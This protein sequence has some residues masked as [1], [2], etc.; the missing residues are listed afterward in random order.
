MKRCLPLLALLACSPP[1][2][3]T[4][5]QMKVDVDP[6]ADET[7]ARFLDLFDDAQDT[8]DVALPALEDTTLAQGI[9]DAWQRGVDVRVV[10]DFDQAGDAGVALLQAADVPLTLADD[11]I[12]YFDFNLKAD[13]AW[14]SDQTIMSH[15]YAEA[16][17]YKAVSA[18]TAG[19]L[20]PGS[21]VVLE[22]QG[23][24]LM[25]DID[26]EH[27]QLF[28]GSDAVAVTAY[29]NAAKSIAD[30][31]WAYPNQTDQLLE[32]W[33]GPQEH[34]TKRVIDAVYSAR[35]SAWV[36]TNDFA[37]EGLTDALQ[38]KAE[39][40]FDMKVVVGPDFGDS[41]PF[42]SSA[43]GTG[44]PDV[45]K[46]R[47]CGDVAVPT[48]VIIDWDPA[49]DDRRYPAKV[50]ILSHDIYSSSRLYRNL[51]VKTDQLIDGNL[52]VIT[53]FDERSGDLLPLRDLWQSHF[54]QATGGLA[55]P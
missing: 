40:G 45:E 50:F 10:T 54:D 7:T 30:F 32:M 35:S 51:P 29:D 36:L 3:E 25:I 27:N 33:L 23:E 52:F 21:R 34:L 18:T 47:L 48:L 55:C 11:G 2:M 13:V 1:E 20:R 4:F 5:T 8:L 49:R 28:G 41:S 37:N 16:D 24:D 6:S 31:R 44:S 9:V 42:L 19:A 14:T 39:L 38:D 53:D 17:G 26:S 43:L 46:R 22:L 12:G 15:A